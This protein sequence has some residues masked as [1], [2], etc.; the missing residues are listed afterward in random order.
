[1]P[2]VGKD[3]SLEPPLDE[4]EDKEEYDDIDE[5]MYE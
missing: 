5:Y 3:L 1:M 4:P 2:R